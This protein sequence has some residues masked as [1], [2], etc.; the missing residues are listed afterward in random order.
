MK[1]VPLSFVWIFDIQMILLYYVVDL[2]TVLYPT[3]NWLSRNAE[4]LGNK[5]QMKYIWSS[6]RT[7]VSLNKSP[8]SV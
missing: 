7:V 6:K 3:I 5:R 8:C 4:L 2:V 1:A